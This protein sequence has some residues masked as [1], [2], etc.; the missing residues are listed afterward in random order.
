M[1]RAMFLAIPMRGCMMRPDSGPATKTRDIKDLVR[2]RE[3]RY[4]DAT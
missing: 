2:P 4:G 3:M 1:L